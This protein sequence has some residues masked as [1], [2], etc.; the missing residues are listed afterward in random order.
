MDELSDRTALSPLT[1]TFLR[2]RY[3]LLK[4]FPY[5]ED[6]LVYDAKPHF[7]CCL[8]PAE[9][10]VLIAFLRDVSPTDCSQ[11]D[12]ALLGERAIRVLYEKFADLRQAGVF[13]PGPASE[14]SPVD[15]TAIREQLAYYDANI[16]L[17]KFC[18][19]VTEE[20]NFRCT[21]CKRTIA[22]DF[23]THASNRLSEED[24][25]KGIR[26]YFGKYTAIFQKLTP[27][28]QALLL[29]VSPPSLSWYGGEPFLNF[30]LLQQTAAYFKSLPW[31]R[32]G[33]SPAD[34]RFSTN[35]NLSVMTGEMLRF[36]VENRVTLFASLDGPAAEHD[37]CRV[38]ATGGGTFQTAY[39]NLLK[40]KQHD[41]QYFRENVSIYG[42]YTPEHDYRQCV[43]FNESI[44]A[45]LCRHFPAEYAGVFVAEAAAATAQLRRDFADK[46]DR[47]RQEARMAAD[48]PE[49]PLEPFASLFPFVT[50]KKD[51][52]SGRNELR[53]SL[54]CPMGFDNL[55]LAAT[56]DYLICHKVSGMPIG[57]CDSG[58]DL[59]RLIE[60][61]RQ[62]NAT[63]NN[64]GC[65][66]CWLVNF[67]DVC[68]ASRMAGD[69]FINPAPAEC[70]YFRLRGEFDFRCFL[71]L[72]LE[73]P[74]LW[75]RI[76]E[77]RNDRRKFIGIIDVNDF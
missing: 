2:E 22:K 46:L 31:Q 3:P 33:I 59:E 35:T 41:P 64:G 5:G 32:F 28:K 24:A 10:S 15:R 39:A 71:Q 18:L 7:A 27:E 13:L 56:G 45:L 9:L 44:G 12:D 36:L 75:R 4:L 67:C 55:M 21:Y 52:P 30:R 70:D 16:L 69:H 38:F 23:R 19:E 37:R 29:Q 58:L 53:L 40:I 43:A 68:A 63:V 42:V 74:D 73:Q 25:Y 47:F 66:S 1:E 8:S 76:E 11:S 72:L 34:L 14:I 65:R 60:L 61:N 51:R 48:Q 49:A 77:Y 62:Y 54:T 26:Y 6:I 50:L 20:C 17:R 57:D